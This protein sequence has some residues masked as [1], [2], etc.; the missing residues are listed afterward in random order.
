MDGGRFEKDA[1]GGVVY[2]LLSVWELRLWPNKD[3]M[4][5]EVEGMTI[6]VNVPEI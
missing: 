2:F 5:D 4:Y 6:S 3:H 1:N